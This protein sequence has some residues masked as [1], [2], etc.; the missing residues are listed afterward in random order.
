MAEIGLPKIHTALISVSDK[1]GIVALA[2]F[3]TVEYDVEIL[4]TGG[5]AAMLREARIPVTDVSSYTGFPECFGGRLKTL[6]PK[7]HGGILYKRGDI[8]HEDSAQFLDIRP[9]DLV[10]V[11]L[12]PFEKTVAKPEVTEDE[13][14][15]EIDIG[16]PAMLRSAAKNYRSVAVVCEPGHYAWIQNQMNEYEGG[17]SLALRR[18]LAEYVFGKTYHY[19]REIAEYL[20]RSAPRV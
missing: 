2:S 19:D 11:N 6:H 20:H 3:L 18:M 15:E 12:Y 9:I 14:I 1:T 7:I 16:G 13:A 8:G 10:V 5:T 4:S 17:T